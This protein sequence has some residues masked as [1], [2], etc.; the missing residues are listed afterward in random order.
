MKEKKLIAYSLLQIISD[1]KAALQILL[2]EGVISVNNSEI[3]FGS[4][5]P[6]DMSEEVTLENINRIK[7]CMEIGRPVVLLH[8]EALYESL[9]DLLNQSYTS[10]GNKNFCRIAVGP[11]SSK[12]EVHADFKLILVVES[13]DIA[14]KRIPAALLNRLEKQRLSYADILTE[15]EVAAMHAARKWIGDIASLHKPKLRLHHLLPGLQ[16]E[17][18]G[19][20]ALAL[21][22]EIPAESSTVETVTEGIKRMLLRVTI[23]ERAVQIRLDPP[24]QST[25]ESERNLWDSYFTA[26]Q[27]SLRQFLDRCVKSGQVTRSTILTHTPPTT[28]LEN[29]IRWSFP[30]F[31]KLDPLALQREQDFRR[32]VVEFLESPTEDLLVVQ[33]YLKEVQRE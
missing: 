16:L 27:N 4:N 9:Y 14:A 5:F 3:I 31:R 11:Q 1:D 23:P 7:A 30:H 6:R 26:P 15:T 24:C 29:I 28:P 8:Q 19:A 25:Y 10:F 12:C 33:L 2:Q 20:V 21:R 13:E 17:S 32:G 18:I 22:K